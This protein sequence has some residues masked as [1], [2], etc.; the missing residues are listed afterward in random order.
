MLT[1]NQTAE[2]TCESFGSDATGVCRFEG[3]AVFV[4][5]LLPG[6]RALVR[7]VKVQKRYAFGRIEQLIDASPDRREPVCPVYRRCGGCSC[8]HMSYEASLEFKRSQVQELLR[9]VGGLPVDVPEVLGMDAPLHYRNKGTYP[10]SL[11][12]GQ[13]V[14]GFFAPHSHDLVPLPEGGC[15]IQRKESSAAVAALLSWMKAFRVLPYDERGHRGLI[16]HI[17]TRTSG[18]GK[19]VVTLV[20]ASPALPHAQELIEAMRSALPGLHGLC[21]IHN[22]RTDNVILDGKL[23]VLWGEAALDMTLCALHFS[24]SP[25]AFFQVNPVQTEKLYSLALDFAGLTGRETVCDCY[26]GAGTISL[27]LAG[28]AQRVIGIEIVPQAIDNAKANAK[29]NGI[30]GA[31]FLCG[32][33]EELLPRL[34]ADGI[35]PDVVMLDPPRKGCEPAVLDAICE[36]GVS[37][38]VYISCGAPALA[39]DAAIL[40][41]RGYNI[42]RIQ[43]VDMFC[44]TGDV[45]TV[46]LLSKIRSAPHIDIDLD[47]TELDV[48][49]AETKAT[50]EEI[51]AYVLEHTGLKVSCLYIAQVKAKHGIIERDCYNKAKTEGNRVPKCPPEKERAIEEALRHFQ[52]IP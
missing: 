38:V 45:E 5:M 16:R 41:A 51:K 37:R 48:T 11:R 8:Q 21:L 24:V 9:R 10:V 35:R 32:K 23:H 36:A 6:E 44:L 1:K 49:A 28:H 39:R 25:Q 42:E 17:M 33:T 27:L 31:E 43:C 4:P 26:C 46:C 30:T 12:E 47:M 19:T 7:I 13:P 22:P 14:C 50:Y 34:V 18:D 20:C 3:M 40:S 52:M 2:M 15:L 29:A